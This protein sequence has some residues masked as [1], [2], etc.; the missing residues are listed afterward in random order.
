VHRGESSLHPSIARKLLMGWSDDSRQRLLPD[1]LTPREAEV[2]H[3]VARGMSNREISEQLAISEAT[4]RSHVSNLLTKL[5]LNS[6]T[7]AAVYALREGLVPLHETNAQLTP[8][9]HLDPG[10]R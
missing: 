3:L 7:Q 10:G 8:Q 5:N 6:R 1:L 4:V 2:L 9:G